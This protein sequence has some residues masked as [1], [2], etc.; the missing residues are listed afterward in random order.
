MLH[1]RSM[2]AASLLVLGLAAQSV[3]PKPAAA[4]TAPPAPRI[5]IVLPTRHTQAINSVVFSFSDDD[6]FAAS[7]GDDGV[8]KLWEVRTGRMI[9]NVAR[10][11][12]NNKY[13]RVTAL[14]SDGKRLLGPVGSDTKVWDAITGREVLSIPD[15]D[16]GKAEVTMSA[17]GSRIAARGKDNAV[18][19]YD[20]AAG[21]ELATLRGVVKVSFSR[22]GRQLVA[23]R[24]DRTV[25]ILDA[26]TGV[27]IHAVTTLD[28]LLTGVAHDRNRKISIVSE[29]GLAR[30]WDVEHGRQIAERRGGKDA[31]ARFSP[32]G[33]WWA[34]ADGRQTVEVLNADTG[35][36]S[37][38]FR[39]PANSSLTGFSR[40]GTLLLFTP[41]ED[42]KADWELTAVRAAT[43]ETV[44]VFKGA[45][46]AT[47][48]LGARHYIEGDDDGTLRL[49]DIENWSEVHSFGGQPA[50]SAAAFSSSG[51]QVALSRRGEV[52][53]LDAETGQRT[54][55]C[56]APAGDA[57]EAIGISPDGRRLA[58]G[59]ENNAVII[60][61]PE[62][63]TVT[64]SLTGHGDA[65]KSVSFSADVRQL[66]SG[67]A[68]GD[69]KIWDIA[70]GGNSR[71]F[72]GN[73]SQA[74]VVAL[75]PDA[76]RAFSGTSD[77]RIHIWNM[78]TGRE[79]K[80]L[81]MLIG[82]VDAMAISPDGRHVAASP[83]SQLLVKRWDIETG[84]ELQ[85]LETGVTGRFVEPADVKYA[86]TGDHLLAAISHNQ[87]VVWDADSGQKK[88]DISWRDQDFKSIAF[89]GDGRRLVTVD[90]AGVIRHWDRRTG[91]LLL[92][93]FPLGGG[94]WL[95]LTP[96]GFF[97]AS[98]NA[99][100]KL[101]VV[102]GLEVS[103]ID[104]VYQSLY[105]PDLVRAKL[106]GDPDG[107]V[108]QAAGKLDLDQVMASGAAPRV[109]ITVPQDG[110]RIA[111]ATVPVEAKVTDAGG[112]I[113]RIEWRVNGVT[114]GVRA[115]GL[116]PAGGGAADAQTVRQTLPL[117]AGD[118]VID[119]VAYNG[120]DL[121]ASPAA[122]IKVTRTGGMAARPRLHVLAVGVDN[123]WDGRLKL[124][125]SVAD[126]RAMAAAFEK[127][128]T[129]VYESAKVTTVI[130]ADVT[131]EHLTAVFA[132]I[133]ADVR[134]SD[135][136][137]LFI[138]GHGRTL[139]GHYYFIPYDFRY[140]D[141]S[142]FAKSAI[143]QD[144]WQQ[145]VSAVQ[146]RKSILIYDTCES[147]AVT[148][149]L[150]PSRGLA[151][152]EEQAT[153]I[154]KLQ[155]AT[156]RTVL[157]ASTDS[158]P[159]LEGYRGHGVLSYAVL[160]ALEKGPVNK[161]GLIEVTGLISFIDDE[162]PALS[163]QAFRRRQVP[164]AK[165][166]G[167]NFAFGKPA[168]VLASADAS[169]SIPANPTHVVIQAADVFAEPGGA[170]PAREKLAPGTLVTLVKTEHGWTLVARSGKPLGYVASTGLAPLQ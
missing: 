93:V 61:D 157:A 85:R 22:D 164:Q 27:R 144:Q 125:F 156:G 158:Q 112:G 76:R 15:P 115:R 108:K 127:V 77:N 51:A 160:E 54:G 101:S 161:D 53:V 58:Y 132:Q 70:T 17:D 13:W 45:R 34:F 40:D 147:G 149:D 150:P 130:D 63:R 46:D 79:E 131:R 21:R 39:A 146:V 72:K 114:L 129:G 41:R 166:A 113:G 3:T 66:I 100:A 55:G 12:P 42:Q 141:E 145:W 128:A 152:I 118:N 169:A 78:A 151:A 24:A 134:P 159:A 19:L 74:N 138:A 18:K 139:D 33:A 37:S 109:A 140:Q 102:R 122:R 95:R 104:Q 117:E 105:R 20:G 44:N 106:A 6:R 83:Y 47:G 94:E 92:T 52:S 82:P 136:F 120:R 170:A 32:D 4:Q 148:A 62:K 89:S 162:V 23:G 9:R 1:G 84:R 80:N 135:V 69:V 75:S 165:F 137:V 60:C 99:A 25:D 91:A 103:S 73:Q 96:E 8:I 111:E 90:D 36:V 155:R 153:A 43:G 87:F 48:A 97:D 142:S 163:F 28:G 49:R 126:A 107:L 16:D 38:T 29:T 65:V 57:A 168:P 31:E 64:Q 5:E 98:P 7:S 133:A 167:S 121:I 68:N 116:A 123:Y 59:G 119:A 30:L 81:R 143:S 50:L 86:T 88:I 35:A 71:T 10:I 26:T 67:D 154:E 14:S 11:D 110:A 56:P 124:N 2:A